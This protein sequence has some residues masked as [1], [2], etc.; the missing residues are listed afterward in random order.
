MTSCK[1]LLTDYRKFD[2]STVK[3]GGNS[4][5]KIVGYGTFVCEKV[6]IKHVAHVEGLGYNLLSVIQLCDA[7]NVVVLR[8]THGSA[9][10]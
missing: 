3:F 9:E 7:S 8:S 10:L 4:S 6:T 1:S 2:G 5:G